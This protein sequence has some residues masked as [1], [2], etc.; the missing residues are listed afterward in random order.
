MNGCERVLGRVW[1]DRAGLVRAD[2]PAAVAEVGPTRSGAGAGRGPLGPAAVSLVKKEYLQ[3]WARKTHAHC[4]LSLLFITI[5]L[6][7]L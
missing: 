3:I 5:L 4:A 7:I 2:G 1:S 6:S